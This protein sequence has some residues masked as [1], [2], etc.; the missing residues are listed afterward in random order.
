MTK[1]SSMLLYH[2]ILYT[3]HGISRVMFNLYQKTVCM[4]D[5]V[6][7]Y[8]QTVFI[9]LAMELNSNAHQSKHELDL[10]QLAYCLDCEL[11]DRSR[12]FSNEVFYK[13]GRQALLSSRDVKIFIVNSIKKRHNS[14]RF[15][16]MLSIA[17]TFC[18]A[19]LTQLKDI[20]TNS[21]ISDEPLNA[22]VTG[23]AELHEKINLY[24]EYLRHQ[25]KRMDQVFS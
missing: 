10:Y 14:L 3:C 6:K 13:K 22:L 4:F 17:S 8:L 21:D 24:I 12:T 9:F 2:C 15:L 23:Y 5:I 1:C 20:N 19:T 16:Q 11:Q 25:P 7:M 18:N